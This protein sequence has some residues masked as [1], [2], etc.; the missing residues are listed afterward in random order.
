MSDWS[1][2]AQRAGHEIERLTEELD[3]TRR[4]RDRF[5]QTIEYRVKE[6]DEA[7]ATIKRLVEAV[8]AGW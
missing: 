1:D 5:A 3:E 2:N 6:L 7:R 8:L 4:D